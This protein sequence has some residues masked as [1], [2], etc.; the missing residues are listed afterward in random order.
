MSTDIDTIITRFAAEHHGV[1]TLDVARAA[2]ATRRER[3]RR[4][5]AGRWVRLHDEVYVVAGTPP[6]WRRDLVAAC[7]AGGADAAASHRSAAE[8]WGL[9]GGR[10]HPPEITCHRWRRNQEDGL[11]VHESKVLETLDVRIVDGIPTVCPE[12]TLVQLGAVHGRAL[13]EMAYDAAC[14]RSLVTEQ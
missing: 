4:V 14:R 11:V 6:S 13:V 7:F 3:Q 12:L 2:N 8:L 5:D 9:P 1:F 10:T